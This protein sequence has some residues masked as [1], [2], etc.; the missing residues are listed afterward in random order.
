MVSDLVGKH[1]KMTGVDDPERGG[2]GREFKEDFHFCTRGH[3]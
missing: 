3:E 2:F 1:A